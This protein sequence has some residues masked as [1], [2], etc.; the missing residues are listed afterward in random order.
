MAINRI[1]RRKRLH[2]NQVELNQNLQNLDEK[3]VQLQ[4]VEVEMIRDG[5]GLK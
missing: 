5:G 3:M 2:K 1:E 4:K